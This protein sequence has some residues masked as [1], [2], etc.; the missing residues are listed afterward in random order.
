MVER[1]LFSPG[2]ATEAKQDD[3]I[4]EL[5][6]VEAAVGAL[7]QNPLTDAE[8]R[9]TP[10]PVV[11]TLV[12]PSTGGNSTVAGTTS[13]STTVLASNASRRGA[14]LFM[15]DTI[16]TGADLY[17]S[18]GATCT[19]TNFTLK[20]AA[21]GYYEVPFGYTGIITGVCSAATGTIRVTEIT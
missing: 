10:V 6:D 16:V 17:I 3:I 2:G 7:E 15:D 8:L 21:Q 9:A 18:L 14:T 5:Q 11:A 1:V 12:Y 13:S 4:A 19:T 20:I